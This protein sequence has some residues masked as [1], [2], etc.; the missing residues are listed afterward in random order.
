M[1]FD[2]LLQIVGT[3]LLTTRP[4]SM[5]D[6]NSNV[7][8]CMTIFTGCDIFPVHACLCVCLHRCGLSGGELAVPISTNALNYLFKIM[9]PEGVRIYCCNLYLR[10]AEYF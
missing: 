10:S 1:Q 9:L 4:H 7:K 5:E 8:K 6:D 3:Y 2:I